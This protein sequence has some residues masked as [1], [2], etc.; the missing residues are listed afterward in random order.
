MLA[1]SQMSQQSK[2]LMLRGCQRSKD[3]AATGVA[4]VFVEWCGVGI[5]RW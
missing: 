3:L 5:M 4:V 2:D 1:N